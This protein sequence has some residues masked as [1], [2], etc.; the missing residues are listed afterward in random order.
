MCCINK[1][2]YLFTFNTDCIMQMIVRDF[3]IQSEKTVVKL[4]V[5][6][7]HFYGFVGVFTHAHRTYP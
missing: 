6:S 3:Y 1:S 5:C 2:I 7:T 4:F